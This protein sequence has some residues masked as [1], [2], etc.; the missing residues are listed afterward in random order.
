MKNIYDNH[1]NIKIFASG[2]SSLKIKEQIQESLAGRKKLYHLFPL[3]FEEFLW[4]KEK[5]ITQLKNTPYLSGDNI[6]MGIL[7]ELLEEYLIYGGYPEVVLSKN[8]KEIFQSIFDLYVK[9]ELV[10][11]L[12]FGKIIGIKKLIEYLALNNG[13]KIKY[14]EAANRC[15]LKQYEVKEYL[16]IL[17][18]TFLIDI[19]RPFYT[20]KNKELVKIPKIY[21][22]DNGVRNYFINNFNKL[23]LR[24]DSGFLFEGL[25]FQE[26]KKNGFENIKFWQDK[27]KHEVDFV[28]DLISRQIPV[29]VKFK[30]KLKHEDFV[31]L[32]IFQEEYKNEKQYLINLGS[33]KKKGKTNIWLPFQ[34]NKIK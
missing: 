20:N 16:E 15:S 1:K 23:S 22:I 14:D 13:Q 30:N 2:S 8:K 24:K 17:K 27:N 12:K 7:S 25:V 33:Q 29:E 32:N 28:L 9:K 31:G 6:N 11:Y 21:F 19:I 3:D 26:F 4:F 18:E 34:I 10:G 5:G